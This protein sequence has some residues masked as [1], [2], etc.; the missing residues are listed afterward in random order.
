[1]PYSVGFT[2]VSRFFSSGLIAQS[3]VGLPN[4]IGRVPLMDHHRSFFFLA[5]IDAFFGKMHMPAFVVL[6]KLDGRL[7][8]RWGSRDVVLKESPFTLA[9]PEEHRC[10]FDCSLTHKLISPT[11]RWET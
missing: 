1:M 11:P 8:H 9:H 3:R 5:V 6:R 2:S 10:S 4:E 7:E